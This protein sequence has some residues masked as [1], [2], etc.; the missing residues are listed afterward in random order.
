MKKGNKKVSRVLV[1]LLAL[2]LTLTLLPADAFAAGTASETVYVTI[3]KDG[4]IVA[5]KNGKA[6]AEAAVTL[7]GKESYTIDD[8]LREA[9]EEYCQGG[10]AAGYASESTKYGLSLTKLWGDTSGNFI[11]QLDSGSVNVLGLD[12]K[13]TDGETLDACILQSMYPDSESY[14]FFDKRTA[15]VSE[16]ESLGLTLKT[17][18]YDANFNLVFSA[19]SGAALTVNG[20]AQSAVTD[21]DGKASVSF[22]K[23]GTYV[24]SAAKSKT[25]GTDSV[26]AITAPVCVVTVKASSEDKKFAEA[27]QK[28]GDALAE[29][30]LV[31]GDEWIALGL[32]RS[33]RSVSAGYAASVVSY[34]KSSIN[35]AGQLSATRST[36]NSRTILA[37]T[38]IGEDPTD[39][40]GY[41]LLKGLTDLNYLKK[42]GLNGPIFA[43]LA[44]DSNGYDIPSAEEGA[45]AVT[46]EKLI[47]YILERQFADGGWALSGE[48]ADPDI[49]A[50]A[51]EALAPYVS[52]DEKVSAAAE[53]GLACL[54]AKQ[55]SDGGYISWGS[56]NCE[57][58]AQVITA[59]TSLG[60]DPSS[61]SR[62]VKNGNSVLDALLA[63]YTGTGSFADAAGGSANAMATEQAYYAMAAYSR[64]VKGQR[65]LFD[66]KQSVRVA[67]ESRYDTAASAVRKAFPEGCTAAILTSGSNWPDALAA[68]SLA[69]AENCPVILT[70]PDHLTAQAASLLTS[71]GTK[72]VLVIGGTGAVSDQVKAAVENMNIGTKRISGDD[73]YETAE[74]IESEAA[75][76]SSGD[77]CLIVSGSG[78]ADALSI[79]AY[80][81]ANKYP[82]LLAQPDGSLSDSTLKIAEKFKKAVICGGENAVSSSTEKELDGKGISAERFGGED[83]Y[84]TSEKIISGLYG[85][86]LSAAAVA[87]GRNFPDALSGSALAGTKNGAVLLIDGSI[88]LTDTQKKI[89]GTAEDVYV[90]GGTAAVSAADKNEIDAAY[91][92]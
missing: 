45:D 12:Q 24:V 9:H 74:Q 31:F 42:Q 21:A 19:C 58:S 22:D 68:S 34:I 40:G 41:N 56:E 38:A 23:A 77:T 15:S 69:G 90:L 3:S 5:D 57:S 47:A 75:G 37:L 78:Y 17:A 63:Y 71:L 11:Y 10:A 91:A 48:N 86:T 76:I 83:R 67:G 25:A 7:T 66:M 26:T 65:S 64:L 2:I 46:R 29:N 59:L 87:S 70:E 50:M 52:S 49:T 28:T 4:S 27:F 80:A 20:T 1:L 85:E 81:Y 13:I 6:L 82:I 51:L 39:A 62:F 60:V 32:S 89:I 54:S 84:E 88:S 43:L 33:G 53:K 36:D 92:A 18:G 8:A 73:R 55:E 35:D 61:D 14:A 72:N 16:G 79:S 30:D 44:F